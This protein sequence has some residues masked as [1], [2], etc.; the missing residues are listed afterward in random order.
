MK[1]RIE[2]LGRLLGLLTVT[3]LLGGILAFAQGSDI[4]GTYEGMVK[5]PGGPEAKLSLVLKSEGGKV[6]ASATHGDKTVEATDGKFENGKLTLNF[7]NGRVLTAKIDGDKLTAHLAD[8]DGAFYQGAYCDI[9]RA[10]DFGANARVAGQRTARQ[11][12]A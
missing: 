4:S 11:G 9:M 1:N 5:H 10:I 7:G 6:T 2:G 12:Q 3:F 8:P